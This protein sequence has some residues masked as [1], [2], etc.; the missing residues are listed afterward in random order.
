[1]GDADLLRELHDAY[2]W[3][4]N[5]A[6]GEDRMDLVWRLADEYLGQALQ[7]ITAMET[8]GCGRAECVICARASSALA[9]PARRSWLGWARRHHAA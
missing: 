4:I 5:A 7:L 8:P 3:E 6:V 1:M 9:E 2:V